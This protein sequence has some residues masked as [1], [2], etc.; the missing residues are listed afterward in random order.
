MFGDHAAKVRNHNTHLNPMTND[1]AASAVVHETHIF[2]D[3]ATVSH[4]NS[5][6]MT[7]AHMFRC[8]KE[9]IKRK[10]IATGKILTK[11]FV[12]D[13]SDYSAARTQLGD[14]LVDVVTSSSIPELQQAMAALLEEA[15][16]SYQPR[17]VV[18]VI[19]S[20]EKC[21][22]KQVKGLVDANFQVYLIHDA[23]KGTID[24]D[25]L[26]TYAT[27]A[28]KLD[29]VCDDNTSSA[30]G[31]AQGGATSS[32]DIHN[33]HMF[34]TNA[35]VAPVSTFSATAAPFMTA[36]NHQQQQQHHAA[37]AA[38]VVVE[39]RRVA[40]DELVRNEAVL[41]AVRSHITLRWCHIT[42]PHV[43]QDCQYAH[44]IAGASQPS[45]LVPQSPPLPPPPSYNQAVQHLGKSP[46]IAPQSLSPLFGGSAPL[47]RGGPTPMLPA[48]ANPTSLSARS[49]N[50]ARPKSIIAGGSPALV[51]TAA[52]TP[53]AGRLPTPA[54]DIWNDAGAN[55][56]ADMDA[57][58]SSLLSAANCPTA[59]AVPEPIHVDPSLR[60]G[61]AQFSSSLA[62]G[63]HGVKEE[64]CAQF[65]F[66]APPPIQF[67]SSVAD[68]KLSSSSGSHA[69]SARG[70]WAKATAA[71]GS[72]Q[73]HQT[74]MLGGGFAGA[75]DLP[76]LESLS[77]SGSP[78][79]KAAPGAQTTAGRTTGSATKASFASVVGTSATTAKPQQQPSPAGKQAKKSLPSRPKELIIDGH[80]VP[81]DLLV[82]NKFVEN[83]I[84]EG[85]LTGRFCTDT[86]AHSM[87]D[88]HNAHR[89]KYA[90]L[91]GGDIEGKS[92]LAN[93]ALENL[94]SNTS[95]KG[96]F[97]TSPKPHDALKCTYLHRKTQ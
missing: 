41:R 61:M 70:S 48:A 66:S 6:S 72:S 16:A 54:S 52:T 18:V 1:A 19:V 95:Y 57:L 92:L 83:C 68:T 34:G 29:E 11:A 74:T 9:F 93:K 37:A 63:I 45:S 94:R 97:C 59:I 65:S 47:L 42:D 32:G 24:E 13:G 10:R 39:G 27:A 88:C 80:S 22:V 30:G 26:E 81:I 51:S 64:E 86:R 25:I 53:P 49:N 56:D 15:P 31:S 44:G 78:Q 35:L 76:T 14:L 89:D 87:M 73:Q 69:T 23:P 90:L 77:S 84:R 91:Q 17:Q 33:F 2:W 4:L 82:P 67:S 20:K 96:N 21:F 79:Q 62:A 46:I 5:I 12:P 28:F 3:Y 43:I 7:P 55:A 50:L 40:T 85:T 60:E 8:I 36:A 75:D 58:L 71:V 38:T